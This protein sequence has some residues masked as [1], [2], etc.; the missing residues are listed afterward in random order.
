MIVDR[1]LLSAKSS[2]GPGVLMD[3]PAEWESVWRY[4]EGGALTALDLDTTMDWLQ[5]LLAD[6]T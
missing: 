6:H 2:N 4:R 5:H 3:R 1:R